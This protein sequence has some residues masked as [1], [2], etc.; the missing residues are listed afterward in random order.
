MALF[1]FT[2]NI[3]EGKPIDVFNYGK[4]QRDFTYIDD[5]VEGV[6]RTLD[7]VAQ[8]NPDWSGKD[9]DAA[10]SKAPYRLYNI[11]S[12]NPCEL[13]RYIEIIENCLG[14]KAEKNLLP[15]QPGDVLATYADVDALIDDVGYKPGTPIEQ[16]V[17]RFV[18][19]Y[20]AFYQV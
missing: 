4:H 18:E 5:I 16:G 8:P 3:L 12:N 7:H 15:M 10:T 13:L 14:R 2:R 9:P 1:M 17:A 19:W 11:G 20:R 6:I